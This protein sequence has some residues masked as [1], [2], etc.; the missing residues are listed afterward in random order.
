MDTFFLLTTDYTD[1]TDFGFAGISW[2]VGG[3][4]RSVLVVLGSPIEDGFDKTA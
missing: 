3:E 1:G 4:L 2:R